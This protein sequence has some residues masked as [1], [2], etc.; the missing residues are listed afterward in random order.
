[1]N[2]SHLLSGLLIVV[3]I[4]K[5]HIFNIFL[6]LVDLCHLYVVWYVHKSINEDYVKLYV[7]GKVLFKLL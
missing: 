2:L 1:M 5:I 6:S 4:D 3:V 7:H